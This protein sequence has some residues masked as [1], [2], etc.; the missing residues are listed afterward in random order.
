MHDLLRMILFRFETLVKLYEAREFP[1]LAVFFPWVLL[2]EAMSGKTAATLNRLGWLRF[3][4]C[5]LMK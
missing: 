3:A 5:Y 1:W 2:N 4:Y